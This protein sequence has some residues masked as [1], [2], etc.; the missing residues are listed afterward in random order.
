MSRSFSLCTFIGGLGLALAGPCAADTAPPEDLATE[1]PASELPRPSELA[2]RPDERRRDTGRGVDLFG[3]RIG[4]GGQWEITAERRG[5][6]DLSRAARDRDRLDQELKLEATL[7]LDRGVTVFAQ[8]VALSEWE[9][10]RQNGREESRGALERGQ[11]W[12]FVPKVGGLPIDVQVG[13]LGLVD[14]RSWWWDDDVD[15]ARVFVGGH[16]WLIDTGLARQV[17]PVST[18]ERGRI[19]PEEQDVVRWFT[20]GAWQW[21]KRHSLEGF[22]LVARDHSGRLAVGRTLA[23]ARAD[24]ADSDLTWLGARALGEERTASGYRFGYWADLA[25]VQG[26]ETRTRFEDVGG[27]RQQV[28][29]HRRVRVRGE[30]WDLGA[31]LSGPGPQRPTLWAGWAVGS[32]DGNADDGTDHAFRQTGLEENKARFGGVKRFRYYGELL[33]PTL[34]NIDIRSVGGSVRFGTRS[35]L[36]LTWHD[37]R[38][39][40][41]SDQLEGTRLSAD[42]TGRDRHLGQATELFLAVRESPATEWTAT[43]ARFTAGKAFGADSGDHAWFAQVGLTINF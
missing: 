23:E 42:P 28:D 32:G 20:R 35:S 1:A 8:L 11:M 33:R 36:D 10:R 40:Q 6:L 27:S 7:A 30:A 15:A 9:T 12:V 22:A 24:A 43:L 2:R 37:Y 25:Q 34:S 31:R 18:E 29:S 39:R 16:N 13:R 4:L 5:N 21:R 41:A 14:E 19:D 17:L 38:Q 26:R 3:R